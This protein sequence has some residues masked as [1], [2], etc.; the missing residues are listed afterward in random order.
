MIPVD[1][2]KAE[3]RKATFGYNK[4]EVRAFLNQV[5]DDMRTVIE[6]N[7]RLQARVKDIEQRI[8][9]QEKI[10]TSMEIAA[11]AINNTLDEIKTKARKEAELI[12]Q[13][14][15]LKSEEIIHDTHK[16]LIDMERKF[17]DLKKE[18]YLL[19]KKL[20]NFIDIHRD[21]IYSFENEV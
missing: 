21:I 8:T 17:E 18:K 19:I 16:N 12:I 1:I 11:V 4:D 14:A 2:K 3:F 7:S 10:K 6:E 5:A 15:K 13:Q 20:K 9:E